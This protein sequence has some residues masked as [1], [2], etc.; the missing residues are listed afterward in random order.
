MVYH[1]TSLGEFSIQAS[2]DS[3][4][5]SVAIPPTNMDRLLQAF[6]R[7][8]AQDCVCNHTSNQTSSEYGIL[9]QARQSAVE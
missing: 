9:T 6:H 4:I 8:S 7:C 2:G 3:D 1:D 5:L